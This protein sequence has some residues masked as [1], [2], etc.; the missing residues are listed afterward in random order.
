MSSGARVI[1]GASADTP[2]IDPD[3]RAAVAQPP[4]RVLVEL[5]LPDLSTDTD[6]GAPRTPAISAARQVV[7][8]RLAGTSYRLVR[9]Y[10]T[11]PLLA[12]EIGP[13]ALEALEKMGDVV[14]LVRLDRPRPP[15]APR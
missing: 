15:I 2:V 5:R 8:A 4:A 11:V 6:P 13:D 14:T 7:L 12:L 3:V 9:Q 10:A 1:R